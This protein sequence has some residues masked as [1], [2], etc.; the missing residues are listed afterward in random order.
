VD[1]SLA[2]LRSDP[3]DG[4]PATL[5]LA[6]RAAFPL[7]A[8]L[9]LWGDQ[10][11]GR[12]QADRRTPGEVIDAMRRTR[13][14]VHQLAGALDDYDAGVPIR[15]VDASGKVIWTDDGAQEQLINDTYLRNAFPP[16][17][18]VSRPPSPETASEKLEAALSDLAAV[19]GDLEDAV[20]AV[21][22]VK[23]IDGAPLVDTDGVPSAHCTA[24]RRIIGEAEEDLVVWGRQFRRRGGASQAGADEDAETAETTEPDEALVEEWDAEAEA[25]ADSEMNAAEVDENDGTEEREAA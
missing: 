25:E 15:A 20:A 4:G 14:G 7:I 13:A 21:R 19:M 10:G 9:K 24:W 2:E 23:G 6:A 11:S 22:A 8:T 12:D 16:A 3:E 5:E 18:T 1:E 17:G